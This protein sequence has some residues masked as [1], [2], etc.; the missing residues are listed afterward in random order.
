MAQKTREQNRTAMAD[1]TPFTNAKLVDLQDSHVSIL[2]DRFAAAN[3]QSGDGD[4]N[5]VKAFSAK[6]VLDTIAA[7][8]VVDISIDV[9]DWDE[10]FGYT[11]ANTVATYG[12]TLNISARALSQSTLFIPRPSDFSNKLNGEAPVINVIQGRVGPPIMV[13]PTTL[14]QFIAPGSST[15]ISNP[16]FLRTRGRGTVITLV[17]DPHVSSQWYVLEGQPLA[18]GR[19]VFTANHTLGPSDFYTYGGNKITFSPNVDELVF[20]SPNALTFTLREPSYYQLLTGESIKMELIQKG[21][22]QV[23]VQ[24]TGS[25]Q[26]QEIG[27]LNNQIYRTEGQGAS[28]II[29][30]LDETTWYVRGRLDTTV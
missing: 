9:D 10:N 5:A 1:G 21:A 15:N 11:L 3:A 22:G 8:S 18:P 25:A 2:D 24:G 17:P 6:D 4:H 27:Y 26:F 29:S 23:T 14:A 12:K 7:R 19:S 30:P 28:L 16:D 13:A 20:D